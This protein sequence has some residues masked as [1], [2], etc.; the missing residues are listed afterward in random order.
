M[1]LLALSALIPGLTPDPDRYP[2][3][4]Q[5]LALFSSLY[6][7]ALGTGGIKPNVSAF[8]ADQFDE[9]DPQ[10]SAQEGGRQARA[11]AGGAVAVGG[12]QAAAVGIRASAALPSP[13]LPVARVGPQGE[14]L[15]LQ[16]VLL[17]DQH[18]QPAGS[19]R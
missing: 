9:T 17:C 4:I 16:L 11:R 18:R 19:H 7:V 5:N 8:G 12:R 13:P 1:V 6:I 3:Q 10:A 2:T 15:L 14:D